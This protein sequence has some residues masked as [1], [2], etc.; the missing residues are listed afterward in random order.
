MDMDDTS[1]FDE[2]DEA[3]MEEIESEDDDDMAVQ[4]N[5]S[6]KTLSMCLTH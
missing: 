4:G 2:A 3:S 6:R 5:K 1:S